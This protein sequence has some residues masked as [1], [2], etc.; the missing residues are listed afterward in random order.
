M[1]IAPRVSSPLF[2]VAV[3]L[4]LAAC[5]GAASTGGHSSGTMTSVEG[6][7]MMWCMK[8]PE[9]NRC[10]AR[11]GVE[12]QICAGNPNNYDSCR[13]AMDQMHGQ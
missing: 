1:R 12:H 13:F 2:L 8:S 4:G 6:S 10:R 7:A 11:S 5:N 9:P 3:L